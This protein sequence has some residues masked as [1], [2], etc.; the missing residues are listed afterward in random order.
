MSR[1]DGSRFKIT[2]G[3]RVDFD[4]IGRLLANETRPQG[5]K[6]AQAEL[7]DALGLSLA[8]FQAVC[9]IAEAMGLSDVGTLK[10]NAIGSLVLQYDRFFD[11]L[12]TLWFCHYAAASN[13]HNL[14]WNTL[15]NDMFARSS[16]FSEADCVAALEEFRPRFSHEFFHK[17]VVKEPRSLLRAYTDENFSRLELL[18][19][20]G[21]NFTLSYR[22]PVPPLVLAACIARFRQ[23]HRNGDATVPV[24]EVA[25]APNSPGLVCQIPE[26]RLRASLEELKTEPGFSLESRADLDQVRLTDDTP[27][28]V[29]M[30]RYY[31][32]R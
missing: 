14:V 1:S 12:G 2:N 27:D 22:E 6:A 13:P 23:R 3:Y 7:V 15:G 28:Y 26:E 10:R 31:V 19:V 24:S 16:R 11:D 29:W 30:E 8:H 25:G 5:S 32:R 9:R 21:D 4:L 17:F 18:R 20:N